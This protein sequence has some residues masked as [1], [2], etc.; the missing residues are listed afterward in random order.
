MK[1]GTDK[2]DLDVARHHPAKGADKLVDLTGRGTADGIGN[3]YAI[4][5]GSIGGL[6]QSH[7]VV[8][9]RPKGV[10]G[11][12]A[13]FSSLADSQKAKF[14]VSINASHTTR[15]CVVLWRKN[16]HYLLTYSITSSAMFLIVS[17]SLP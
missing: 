17:M 3:T 4:D 5:T 2:M 8:E 11:R 14:C 15:V 12:K 1:E 7:D 16:W 13:D 9:I 6:V 10:L